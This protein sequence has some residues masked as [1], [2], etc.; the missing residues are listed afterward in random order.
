MAYFYKMYFNHYNSRCILNEGK[1]RHYLS[2]QT[3][4]LWDRHERWDGFLI[5]KKKKFQQ[6][7]VTSKLHNEMRIKNRN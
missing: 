6:Q 5:W 1:E 3:T 7:K 2:M 4:H